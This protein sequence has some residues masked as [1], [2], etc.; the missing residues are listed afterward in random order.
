M[1]YCLLLAAARVVIQEHLGELMF[2][3]R[4]YPVSES[5]LVPQVLLGPEWN[6]NWWTVQLK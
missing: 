4:T 2:I 1:V 3:I 5:V 6:Y